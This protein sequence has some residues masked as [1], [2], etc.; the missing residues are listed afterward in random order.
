M[1]KTNLIYTHN[2]STLKRYT[3]LSLL[4][5][6]FRETIMMPGLSPIVEARASQ[7]LALAKAKSRAIASKDSQRP[8]LP[9][10]T[11]KTE[12]DLRQPSASAKAG[13]GV[14]S[15]RPAIDLYVPPHS[16]LRSDA[17][18]APA[19]ASRLS[20][21]A[22]GAGTGTDRYVPPHSRADYKY[23]YPMAPPTH[24]RAGADRYT[25]AHSRSGYAA[26]N[27]TSTRSRAPY[28]RAQAQRRG[29]AELFMNDNCNGTSYAS[30]ESGAGSGFGSSSTAG[31]EELREMKPRGYVQAVQNLMGRLLDK[32][33]GEGEPS[34]SGSL[35]NPKVCLLL[36]LVLFRFPFAVFC[37]AVRGSGSGSGGF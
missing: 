13:L 35:E 11:A 27:T 6:Y 18:A 30:D 14:L 33:E 17:P 3:P 4:R 21:T 12:L 1:A 9:L 16:R 22:A 10:P 32:A 7:T 5:Y 26:G 25:P 23:S 28:G 36:V 2:T 20:R 24:S 15:S 29:S 19:L 37:R 34:R 31:G 8:A